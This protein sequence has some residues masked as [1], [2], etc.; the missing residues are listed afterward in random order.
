ML[1]ST[2]PRRS[3]VCSG[4]EDLRASLSAGEHLKIFVAV[5]LLLRRL[6]SLSQG[7]H[8]LD[9]KIIHRK[10]TMRQFV[11]LV[12]LGSGVLRLRKVSFPLELS[13]VRPSQTVH[14]AQQRHHRP[15]LPTLVSDKSWSHFG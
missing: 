8:A 2:S 13:L 11:A 15:Q 4:L 10:G 6:I 12:G 9:F 3:Q 7:L 14:P 1:T 5:I